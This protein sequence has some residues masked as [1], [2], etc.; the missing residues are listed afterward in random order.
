[1]IFDMVWNK[2]TIGI[3]YGSVSSHG[4]MIFDRIKKQLKWLSFQSTA[5]NASRQKII[6]S[7][8]M[9]TSYHITMKVVGKV[10]SQ[11]WN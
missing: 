10:Q 8:L 7:L 3:R 4:I 2:N 5:A 6:E 1:M 11:Q 9:R